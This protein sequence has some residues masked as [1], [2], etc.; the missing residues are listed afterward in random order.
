ML[1]LDSDGEKKDEHQMTSKA[2]L[3]SQSRRL[4]HTE[5]EAAHRDTRPYTS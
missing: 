5:Q 3:E 2:T 1:E 4:L